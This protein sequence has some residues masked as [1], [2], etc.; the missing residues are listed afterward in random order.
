MKKILVICGPTA[1]GKTKLAIRLAKKFNGEI[2]S[3]DSRQVFKGVDIGSG[4]DLPKNAK[5]YKVKP[6]LGYYKINNVKVW[7]YD[8]IEPT[9]EFSVAHYSKIVRPLLKNILKSRNLPIL[10]GGTG[11]YI[12]AIIDGIETSDI[13]KNVNLRNSL[14]NKA[15]DD[16]FEQLAQLDPTKAASLNISDKMN[17]RRLIRAIEIAEWELRTGV[18]RQKIKPL[19]SQRNLL[20]L[21]LD[22]EIG[23]LLILI[24][25]R[26]LIRIDKGFE[27]E[28]KRLMKRVSIT[29]QAMTSLGYK[30]WTDYLSERYTKSEAIASWVRAEEKYAKQQLSWFKKDRRINWFNIFDKDYLM[31]I[32]K[33]VKEWHNSV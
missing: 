16:L 5:L 32:E 7:G 13:P 29:S 30:E 31:N 8:L 1:T 3:A 20:V 26:V 21:G 11:F 25:K 19:V 9:K 33:L 17:P 2:L 6:S 28:V 27:K 10:V 14:E 18:K 12:K 4:K 24:K 15:K 23:K 22:G